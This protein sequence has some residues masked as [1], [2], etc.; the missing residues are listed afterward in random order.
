MGIDISATG[1]ITFNSTHESRLNTSIPPRNPTVKVIS[2]GLRTYSIFRR[3]R[4]TSD[5]KDGNPFIYA[6]KQKNGYSVDGRSLWHFRPNFNDILDECLL[7]F[8]ADIVVP[9]PSGHKIASYLAT[10]ISRRHSSK[11]T[12]INCLEKV[13]VGSILNHCQTNPPVL[14]GKKKDLYS[15]QIRKWNKMPI[16][17]LVSMKEV[18]PT[19]RGLFSPLTLINP[20]INFNGQ[21]VVLIDDLLSSGCTLS[22]AKAHINQNNGNVVAAVCLLSAL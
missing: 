14:S 19:I 11:P 13:T 21:Q 8:N 18:N 16:G 4:A 9:M 22:S 5:N 10:K 20:A 6:L 2:G 17:T 3:V 7:Q 1:V 12:I 15:E